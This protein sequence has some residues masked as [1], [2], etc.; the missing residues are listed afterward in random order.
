[1]AWICKICKCGNID[2]TDRCIHCDN[3]KTVDE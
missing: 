2:S 3:P 1:M